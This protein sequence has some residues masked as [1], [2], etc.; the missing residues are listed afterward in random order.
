MFLAKEN[1]NDVH[2]LEFVRAL[3]WTSFIEAPKQRGVSS[4]VQE[5]Y[6]N[7]V[8][9]KDGKVFVREKLDEDNPNYDEIAKELGCKDVNAWTISST[10]HKPKSLKLSRSHVDQASNK[11]IPTLFFPCLLTTLCA[12]VKVPWTESEPMMDLMGPI[13]SVSI[14]EAQEKEVGK[15]LRFVAKL[16]QGLVASS[17]KVSS[18]DYPRSHHRCAKL[19][20]PVFAWHCRPPTT[21]LFRSPGGV[22]ILPFIPPKSNPVNNSV[23]WRSQ[24]KHA[25]KSEILPN[26][27]M[28][29]SK[30]LS[31]W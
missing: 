20:L 18:P 5:F 24:R 23:R 26:S 19:S 6:A 28:T 12:Q 29:T 27:A 9:R 8:E 31:I 7:Y 10:T 13:N 30:P 14:C 4:I 11:N 15:V 3:K 2:I 21:L 16:C 22:A 17:A 1:F 25:T